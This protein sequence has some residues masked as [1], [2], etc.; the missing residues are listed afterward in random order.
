M[1]FAYNKLTHVWKFLI[2][3]NEEMLYMCHFHAFV[4]AKTLQNPEEKLYEAKAFAN[5]FLQVVGSVS[6]QFALL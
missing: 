2:D 5:C 4:G 1:D 6:H 3:L